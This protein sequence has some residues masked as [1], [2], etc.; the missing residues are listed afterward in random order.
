MSVYMLAM[1]KLSRRAA[2]KVALWCAIYGKVLVTRSMHSH[3]RMYKYR[4][5]SMKKFKGLSRCCL[6]RCIGYPLRAIPNVPLCL[7]LVRIH[8]KV[9]E[10][11]TSLY[12]LAASCTHY[13]FHFFWAPAS[14][15]HTNA[16]SNL[17]HLISFILIVNP[18]SSSSGVLPSLGMAPK[19]PKTR[20]PKVS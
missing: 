16:L 1:E 20:P 10:E 4:R 17:R 7:S 11:A 6:L 14:D 12:Y 15:K 13:L 3:A 19:R 9:N 8:G 5:N 2:A 18:Y